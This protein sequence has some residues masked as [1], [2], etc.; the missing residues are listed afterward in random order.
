M[1]SVLLTPNEARVLAAL[2]EKSIA[3]PQYYPMTVNALT[4]AS[5]QKNARHPIMALS[6]GDVGA[7]LTRLEAERLVQRDDL[8]GR[9]PKWRHRFQHQLLLKPHTVAVLAT[10]MLRGPQTPAEIRGNA[11][12]LGGPA[13]AEG[14]AAA[15]AD[16]G[17]RA[18]PFVVQLPRAPGQAAARW[19]HTLCGEPSPA[20]L[21]EPVSARPARSADPE[22][23]APSRAELEARLAALEARVAELER[24]LLAAGG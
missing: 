23:G 15:L 20:D 2:V 5:N 22:P 3:T 19:M 6:E 4:M 10:L 21:A 12:G 24:R 8:A 7:A 14:I 9:V 13:D 16:L 1:T 11:A 18:Q 17:D